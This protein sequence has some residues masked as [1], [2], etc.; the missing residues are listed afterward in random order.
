MTHCEFKVEVHHCRPGGR[1]MS[2]LRG[3]KWGLVQ[4]VRAEEVSHALKGRSFRRCRHDPR[5]YAVSRCYFAVANFTVNTPTPLV[6]VTCPARLKR[7][8]S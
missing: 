4:Y 5:T 2:P 8:T 1:L 3:T 7:P 6:I